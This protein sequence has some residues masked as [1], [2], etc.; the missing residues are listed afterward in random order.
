MSK[1]KRKK[2]VFTE[3]SG[4]GSVLSVEDKRKPTMD[5]YDAMVM[6]YAMGTLSLQSV[7]K[8]LDIPASV[9]GEEE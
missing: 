1:R 6:A 5:Q 8:S 7:L 2:T 3:I 4:K 9:T